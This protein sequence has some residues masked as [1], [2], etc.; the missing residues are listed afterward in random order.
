VAR[1]WEWLLSRLV[2]SGM[3]PLSLGQAVDHDFA[4]LCIAGQYA[5][6]ALA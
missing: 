2:I 4:A 6:C 5:V 3:A 1:R